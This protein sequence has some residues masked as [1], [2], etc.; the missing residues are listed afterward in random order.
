MILKRGNSLGRD[1][2]DYTLQLVSICSRNPC[3]VYPQVDRHTV[4]D[5]PLQS[6]GWDVFL[7]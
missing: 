7:R 3:S 5:V 2:A 6:Y 1:G 4:A